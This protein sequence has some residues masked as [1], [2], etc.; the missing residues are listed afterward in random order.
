MTVA[1][2]IAVMD[3]GRIAQVG[4]P[5]EIYERPNS[6]WVA[7][8][9]G[10]VNLIEGRLAAIETGGAIIDSAAGRF[11]AAEASEAAPGGTV[12]LAVRPEK[13]KLTREKPADAT[14][15][16]SGEVVEIAYL[17]NSSL[18][19]IRTASGLIVKAAVPNL[20]RSI[21]QAVD[22]HD[23][24]HLSWPAEAGIVLTR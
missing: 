4:A 21:G 5:A 18:Y 23:Q 7:D 9:V 14:N 20:T 12:W 19:E 22:L 16:V 13:I 3:R 15:C 2:R 17:G 11:I 8:F 24:V 6:R 1:D 10:D